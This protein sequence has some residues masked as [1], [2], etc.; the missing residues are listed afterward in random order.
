MRNRHFH[1]ILLLHKEGFIVI[2][3]HQTDG[4]NTFF[5][6]LT[7]ELSFLRQLDK[8]RIIQASKRPKTPFILMQKESMICLKHTE[9]DYSAVILDLKQ[10]SQNMTDTDIQYASHNLPNTFMTKQST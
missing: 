5:L 8:P 4:Q 10:S 7:E 3:E 9:E 6:L 1:M 2:S